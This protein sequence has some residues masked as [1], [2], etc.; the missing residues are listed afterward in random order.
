M[1]P[2]AW[3]TPDDES[4]ISEGQRSG[5]MKVTGPLLGV[6]WDGQKLG[7]TRRIKKNKT[8]KPTTT[9]KQTHR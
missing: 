6:R 7:D 4:E 9:K 8:K 1:R 2:F 5:E 3:L